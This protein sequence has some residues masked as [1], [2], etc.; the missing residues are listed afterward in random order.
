V[1]RSSIRINARLWEAKP[2]RPSRRSGEGWFL[3]IDSTLIMINVNWP[4]FRTA[5]PEGRNFVVVL[6]LADPTPLALY[7][8]RIKLISPIHLMG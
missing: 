3:K 1:K 2:L 7:G 4:T 6:Q 5:C 8:L